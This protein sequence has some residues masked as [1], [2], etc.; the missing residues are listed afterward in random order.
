MNV[1]R[2]QPDVLVVGGGLVGLT[3][4]LV[5]RHHGLAVTLLERR[6]GSSP[7]PKARRVNMR[8]MEIFRELGLAELVR[9]AARE[10]AGHDRMAA[11]RTLAEA[12]LLPLWRP[13]DESG[14]VIEPS[15]ELPCLIAQ[16]LLEPV[17]REAAVRG[18]ARV[19]FG[20]EVTEVAQDAETVT[21]TTHS[22][23]QV[24]ARYLIA[25]D[26]ARSPIREALGIT[27]SGRG[28]LGEPNVNVYFTA[29]LRELVRDKPFNLCQI[30]HPQARGGLCSVDGRHRWVFMAEGGDTGRDWPRVLETAVGA[31]LP[32]LEVHSVLTWQAEMRVAD[33]YRAG[34]I[35]LAGD[36][37][38]V[39]PPFAASGANTGIA[40][41]HDLGWKLAAALR[42]DTGPLDG[43]HAERHAAGWFT[44]EQSSIRT[45][46]LRDGVPGGDGLAH[47]YVLACGG[48]QYPLPGITETEPITEFAPAGRVGTRI[49]HRWLAEG[50]S[51]LDLAGPD[52]ALVVA[53]SPIPWQDCGFPVHQVDVDFLEP[54][55]AVLLRPDQVIAWRGT[56]P[57]Q[58]TE[59]AV[60]DGVCFTTAQ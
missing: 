55:T 57:R 31:P 24:R 25:A 27:R 19:R 21:A 54:G 7:Q 28:A 45:V 5:L 11:G 44:A 41:V 18:G 42:G 8:T 34:R 56:D 10:L 36:A 35:L 46:N 23:E 12:G 43:Y 32:D 17:L 47:P 52:W 16:D 60:A 49:P 6:T 2:T 30:E 59:L 3:A 13:V 53:G 14:T 39:M 48:F 29:D 4:A 15:P 22:G 26:G 38:H 50:R 1:Q 33:R 9:A 37:A 20:T 58:L 51:T 40:D